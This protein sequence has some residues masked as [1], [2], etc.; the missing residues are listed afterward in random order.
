MSSTKSPP[1]TALSDQAP[2]A[3]IALS[4]S[5]TIR[6]TNQAAEALFGV[7]RR[8]LVGGQLDELIVNPEE[9]LSLTHHARINST[10][11]AAPEVRLK[12][13][14][15]VDELTAIVRVRW[16][17]SGELVLAISPTLSREAP[18]PVVGVASFGRILGHEIKNPLA[19]ISGA[20]QLLL[21]QA[22]PSQRELLS[23]IC[24]ESGRIERL[25]NRL[26]AFELFSAPQLETMN[27]HETLD[28]VVAMEEAAFD[29]Q[30]NFVRRYDPSLPDILGDKDHLHE[31]FQ[32]IIR[33]A[34]EAALQNVS[35]RPAVVE[36]RTAFE[37]RF[38]RRSADNNRG[39]RR[40]LRVDVFD[41]G[42]GPPDENAKALFEAFNSSK[43]AGR[44]LGLTVVKEVLTAHSGH[45]TLDT[46]SQGTLVSVF[47]PIGRK[48]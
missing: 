17:Q 43:S 37:S 42:T 19:G 32:N 7:S 14:G 1:L 47:L 13:K 18:D 28:R 46:N 35:D 6:D 2:V 20:A 40:A 15:L 44:G 33:N 22:K 10:D 39:L 8:R 9:I 24:E 48:E 5:D 36:V 23:L 31:A 29:G 16:F 34:I 21:R 30:L 41:S 3:L 26:S 45:V 38:A 4:E 27:I 25:I 11:T 12:P